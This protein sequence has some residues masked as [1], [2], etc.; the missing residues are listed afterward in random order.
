[1]IDIKLSLWYNG[2][3]AAYSSSW[4]DMTITS[5]YGITN[6]ANKR[7]I[8]TTIY[9]NGSNKEWN[10]ELF[11]GNNGKKTTNLIFNDEIKNRLK[12]I[13]KNGNEI[14]NHTYSHVSLKNKKLNN[15]FILEIE[16]CNKLIKS[17]TNQNEFTF[18]YPHGHLPNDTKIS[19]YIKNKFISSRGV[20]YAKKTNKQLNYI[21]QLENIDLKLLKTIHIGPY[22]YKKTIQELNYILDYTLSKKGWLIEY[23]HGW[24]NDA[25]CPIDKDTLLAHYDYILNKNIWCDTI[26]NISKYI[27]QRKSINFKLIKISEI[28]YELIFENVVNNSPLTFSFEGNLEIIQNNK[29]INIIKYNKKNYFNLYNYNKCVIKIL[30]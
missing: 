22:P 3:D 8:K 20:N 27:K 19:E 26:L 4:D 12:I 1:M 23:G 2:C 10:T 17:I 30:Q 18:C 5:I 13:H 28:K 25:W 11:Y 21:N 9:I 16:K 24:E 15:S 14:G 6:E 7:N 29:I